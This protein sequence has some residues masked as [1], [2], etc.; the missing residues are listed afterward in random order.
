[1]N[2]INR[3]TEIAQKDTTTETN[4]RFTFHPKRFLS[5]L[6]QK[7]YLSPKL[8][9]IFCFLTPIALMF[10]IYLTRGLHPFGDGTP[11]VLDLNSQ[12]AYFFEGLR[13]LIY[14]DAS[15]FLYAGF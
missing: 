4:H 13:N 5:N 8:Y 6:Q 9:L 7:L 3:T 12:Y 2:D 11:L 14:G 15:S 10:G 1:M